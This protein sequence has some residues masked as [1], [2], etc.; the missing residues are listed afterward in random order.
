MAPQPPRILKKNRL[1]ED[2]VQVELQDGSSWILTR[3]AGQVWAT[4]LHPHRRTVSFELPAIDGLG[5]QASPIEAGSMDGSV[6]APAQGRVQKVLAHDGKSV[7]V[8]DTLLV[9]E[10]M[11]MEISVKATK[12]GMITDLQLAPGDVVKRHQILLRIEES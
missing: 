8:G 4:Q 10:S 5:F 6:K 1:A 2:T 9:L 7:Q 3:K 11:K 12:A